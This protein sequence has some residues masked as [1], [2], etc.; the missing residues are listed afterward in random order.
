MERWKGGRQWGR[1]EEK[2]KLRECGG[3]RQGE[4]R[5]RKSGNVDSG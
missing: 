1:E 4:K 3:E 5:G 2:K